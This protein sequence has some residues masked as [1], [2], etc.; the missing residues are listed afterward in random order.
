MNTLFS[1]IKNNIVLNNL[2]LLF[3]K[4][5]LING[6]KRLFIKCYQI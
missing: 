2:K 5:E 4:Y 6:L 3:A 1:N